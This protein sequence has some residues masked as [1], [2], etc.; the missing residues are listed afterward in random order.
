MATSMCEDVRVLEGWEELS[1]HVVRD[2][3]VL[4]SKHMQRGDLERSA[5]ESF[6]FLTRT[7]ETSDQDGKAKVELGLQF[8]LLKGAKHSHKSCSLTEAH[9]AVK[10]TLNLNSF[11]HNRHTLVE[12][13]AFLTLLLSV[14]T[15]SLN[16]RKP[17]TSGVLIASR[18]RS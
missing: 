7:A 8:L 16:V 5:V 6:V 9:Y 14:E 18:S 1:A 10:W 11:S 2:H 13:Q 3:S 17:P 12:A 15:P 4:Q